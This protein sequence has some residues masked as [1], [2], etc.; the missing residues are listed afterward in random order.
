[1]GDNTECVAAHGLVPTLIAVKCE[2]WVG[3][4]PRNCEPLILLSCSVFRIN[5]KR[6]VSTGKK[7]KLGRALCRCLDV[8]TMRIGI[9]YLIREKRVARVRHETRH[10][11]KKKKTRMKYNVVMRDRM[12]FTN[13]INHPID[14]TRKYR[15]EDSEFMEM[16]GFVC[17]CVGVRRQCRC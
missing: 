9:G 12:P 10:T 5:S 3:C 6:K 1:M 7:E 4:L 8:C 14:V 15:C 17:V 11:H 2:L 16:P 13:G